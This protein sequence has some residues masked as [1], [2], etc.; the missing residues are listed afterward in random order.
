MGIARMDIIDSEMA[1]LGYHESES[2]GLVWKVT[3]AMTVALSEY[4]TS[5]VYLHYYCSVLV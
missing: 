1:Y 4:T 2:Y 3:I 5:R